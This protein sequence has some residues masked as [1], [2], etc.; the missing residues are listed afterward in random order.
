MKTS[1]A[2]CLPLDNLPSYTSFSAGRTKKSKQKRKCS[3]FR[4]KSKDNELA[5]QWKSAA[6]PPYKEVRT[7]GHKIIW[8]KIIF[9]ISHE[10]STPEEILPLLCP[11]VFCANRKRSS[12]V[13]LDVIFNQRMS[14]LY[15]S[16][17][18]VSSSIFHRR[19][20]ASCQASIPPNHHVKVATRT[21]TSITFVL[22]LITS[23]LTRSRILIPIWIMKP[24]PEHSPEKVNMK[25]SSNESTNFPKKSSLQAY[26]TTQWPAAAHYNFLPL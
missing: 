13:S 12:S 16:N 6:K 9:F 1:R 20:R 2:S 18:E 17:R 4:R 21:I 7:L 25:K 22:C 5:M 10:Q 19:F 24:I 8:K 23:F 3:S 15:F 26:R 14:D 11:S